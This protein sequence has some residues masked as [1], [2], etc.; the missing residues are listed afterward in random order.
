MYE[1]I[2]NKN[3]MLYETISANIVYFVLNTKYTYNKIITQYWIEQENTIV[4]IGRNENCPICFENIDYRYDMT[5]CC[6]NECNNSVHSMC[7]TRLYCISG[8][9]KCVVCRTE[10]MPYIYNF[11]QV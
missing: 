2:K 5:I 8:K 4:N 11:M 1:A 3:I 6:K 7:W 9:T 10:T